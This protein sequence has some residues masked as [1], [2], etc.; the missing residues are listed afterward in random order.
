MGVCSSTNHVI[1][2]EK[3]VSSVLS[4]LELRGYIENEL[5]R[6]VD[7]PHCCNQFLI[8]FIADRLKPIDSSISAKVKWT[9]VSKDLKASFDP[10][11]KLDSHCKKELSEFQNEERFSDLNVR[12]SHSREKK[13]NYFP[14]GLT[15][16]QKDNKILKEKGQTPSSNMFIGQFENRN[17]NLLQYSPIDRSRKEKANKEYDIT[18]TPKRLLNNMNTKL[19]LKLPINSKQISKLELKQSA[20]ASLNPSNLDNSEKQVKI[21]GLISNLNFPPT[22]NTFSKFKKPY[23][24]RMIKILHRRAEDSSEFSE[25]DDDSNLSLSARHKMLSGL[26]HPKNIIENNTKNVINCKRFSYSRFKASEKICKIEVGD[27][28]RNYRN[29][30]LPRVATSY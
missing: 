30:N 11:L 18:R 15:N 16:A 6:Q 4:M 13:L 5:I 12:P 19:L 8:K 3:K 21:S 1:Q 7:C 2:P 24:P 29:S 25:S 10:S 23:Q 9:S 28:S 14:D 20:K 17:N 26:K 22:L 27:Q